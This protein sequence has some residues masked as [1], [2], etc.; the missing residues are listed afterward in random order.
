MNDMNL[1]T[2]GRLQ[3]KIQRIR[4]VFSSHVPLSVIAAQ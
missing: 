4:H 1:I 2:A 3:G